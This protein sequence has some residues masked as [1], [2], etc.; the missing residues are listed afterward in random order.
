MNSP[1]VICI[2]YMTKLN[3][4]RLGRSSAKNKPQNNNNNNNNN[5]SVSRRMQ[6]PAPVSMGTM[7][8][9]TKPQFLPSSEGVR[10]RHR[11]Y[12]ADIGAIASSA[13]GIVNTVQLNPGLGSLGPWLA[14]IAQ[15]FEMYHI[16]SLKF[17]FV[18]SAP[19]TTQGTFYMAID[20][21]AAD[22]A[23]ITKAAML[24]NQSAIGTSIWNPCT[25]SYVPL[26]ASDQIAKYTRQLAVSGTDIKTYDIGILYLA[27]ETA[28]TASPGDLYC[29]YDIVLKIPQVPSTTALASSMKSINTGGGVVVSSSSDARTGNIAIADPEAPAATGQW[30]FYAPGQYLLSLAVNGTSTGALVAVTPSW[31]ISTGGLVTDVGYAAIDTVAASVGLYEAVITITDTAQIVY[32][33]LANLAS[34]VNASLRIS[35]YGYSLL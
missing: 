9:T 31:S 5:N 32:L 34:V 13:Y 25:L 6:V 22:A 14:L 8:A 11:E 7:I 33:T 20:Y 21:D 17:H 28:L 12:I 19:T 24:S 29:E 26:R 15:N 23:P 16:N 1:D 30:K 4:N 10:I 2:P 3:Q 27:A 18:S 35:K